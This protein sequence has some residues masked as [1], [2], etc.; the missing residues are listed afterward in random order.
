MERKDQVKGDKHTETDRKRLFRMPMLHTL[1][2]RIKAARWLLTPHTHILTR[3][4]THTA[5][6]CQKTCWAPA[7][8]WV[9]VSISLRHNTYKQTYCAAWLLLLQ[10]FWHFP[11]K[12]EKIWGFCLVVLRE[13]EE[14][15]SFASLY[16]VQYRRAVS[17]S[18]PLTTKV[19]PV[20]CV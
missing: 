11:D 18:W 4:Y 2:A 20:L 8:R 14:S 7:E 9:I 12:K 6:C 17:Y 5:T 3:T 15:S 19:E 10:A 16:L 13:W 1:S